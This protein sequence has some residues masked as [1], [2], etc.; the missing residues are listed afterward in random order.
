[1]TIPWL[2]LTIFRYTIEKRILH[3]SEKKPVSNEH[4]IQ[5]LLLRLERVNQIYNLDCPGMLMKIKAYASVH[6]QPGTT[7]AM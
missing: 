2:D 3:P 5:D 6:P 7:R 4:N 1:M